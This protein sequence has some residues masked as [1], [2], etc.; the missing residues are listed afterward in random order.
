M[1]TGALSNA[2]RCR[3]P[4]CGVGKL[5]AGFLQVAERCG[6]C[7]LDLK[8]EDSGDGAAAFLIFFIGAIVVGLAFKLEFSAEPPFWVHL[9]LWP[10]VI[11]GLIVI[12]APPAKAWLIAQQYRHKSGEGR[13]EGERPNDGQ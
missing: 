11:V 3:C 9:L 12:T 10:P 4:R 2:M 7:G 6:H 8:K 13:Q 1:A 5:Y